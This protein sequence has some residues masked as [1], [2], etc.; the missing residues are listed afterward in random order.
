[1]TK[2]DVR[3]LVGVAT[4]ITVRMVMSNLFFKIGGK[5]SNKRMEDL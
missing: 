4:A 3:R 2:G 5:C 1:M